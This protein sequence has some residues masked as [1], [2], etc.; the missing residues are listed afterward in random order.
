MSVHIHFKDSI[1]S[2]SPLLLVTIEFF[3][4]LALGRMAEWKPWNYPELDFK[5]VPA[6]W[7]CGTI[8]LH[9]SIALE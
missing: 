2:Y 7:R 5:N 6:M 3:L 1:S 4:V 8:D 9:V